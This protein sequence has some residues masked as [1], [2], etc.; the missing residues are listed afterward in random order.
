MQNV[1]GNAAANVGY[2]CK[3]RELV[4]GWRAIWSETKGTTDPEAPFGLVTLASSGTEGGPNMGA[5]RLAQT[6]G[7]GVLPNSDI[8]NSFLA[9][10]GDLQDPWG[11]AVGPCF[12]ATAQDWDCCPKGAYTANRSSAT[13]VRGTGGH[14]EICDNAC[15]AAAGTP[16]EGGI[17]PRNKKPVGFR[18]GTAAFGAVYDGK[19]AVT[20]P[21]LAGCAVSAGTLKIDFNRSLLRGERVVLNKY[22][23]TLNNVFTGPPPAIPAGNTSHNTTWQMCYDTIGEVCKGH[24]KD[25]LDC[26]QCKNTVPG[27]WDKLS[28]ACGSR[29][30]NNFHM[31]CHSYFPSPLTMAGSLVEVLVSTD[32]GDAHAAFCVEPQGTGNTST[33]PTWA[34]GSATKP[35]NETAGT[36]FEVDILSSDGSSVTVDLSRLNGSAPVAVRYAWGT[37]DCCNRA[38]GKKFISEPCDEACPITT[39]AL[40]PANPFIARLGSDGKCACVPPQ[41]C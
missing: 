11:P 3:Q 25:H 23:S 18:L 7:H 16:T 30:I 15:A 24:M 41:V 37:L 26:G 28:A 39:A 29:P 4:K 34:G 14:P 21:T 1:K 2:S 31:C 40:I 10:A 32:G 38:N 35:F 22:N 9:Q 12:H 36:W 33:C 5:M 20:G 13:C 17:H 6:A 8:P 27:A 19:G